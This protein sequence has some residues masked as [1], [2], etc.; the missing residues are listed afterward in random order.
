MGECLDIYYRGVTCAVNPDGIPQMLD[1][2]NNIK[3]KASIEHFYLHMELHDYLMIRKVRLGKYPSGPIAL[4]RMATCWRW[5]RVWCFTTYGTYSWSIRC[6]VLAEMKVQK[7]DS[8][9]SLRSLPVQLYDRSLSG[10][11][12][13]GIFCS[14]LTFIER[15][16]RRCLFSHKKTFS[17]PSDKPTTR[18]Q[19]N[20]T[21]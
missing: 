4:C 13:S 3:E 5:C 19:I 8:P 21:P 1:A 10:H 17:T 15:T 7:M 16:R 9:R 2:T 12:S 14:P 6:Q 18:Y 20:Y 11:T